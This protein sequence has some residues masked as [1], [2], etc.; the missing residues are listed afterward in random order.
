MTRLLTSFFAAGLALS[1]GAGALAQPATAPAPAKKDAPKDQPK[2]DDKP[3]T[4][5]PA[6]KMPDP[7][8]MEAMM[9][10]LGKPGAQHDW[11]KGME[12]TWQA[13]CS[14]MDMATGGTK[15]SDAEATNKMVYGGRYLECSFKGRMDGKFFYG[16]NILGYSNSEKQFQSVW[17]D[18]MNTN[19]S[20]MTGQ[21]DSAGKV[22]T[23]HGE[24]TN[25]EDGK[26]MKVRC[27]FTMLA[28]D[29]Y[30]F[31]YYMTMAGQKE[32]KWM[33]IDYTKG[34]AAKEEK[35]DEKEAKKDDKSDKK[36]DKK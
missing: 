30:T 7:K 9:E 23:L 12:G 26:K 5:P 2:K 29:H 8:E 15:T 25:P 3:A 36:N 16:T 33:T 35:K 13:K 34:A 20:T 31:D 11:L 24:E 21:T 32:M 17:Y 19:I 6:P 4:T 18:S 14:E 27:V 28:K 10:A 1:L 22:L